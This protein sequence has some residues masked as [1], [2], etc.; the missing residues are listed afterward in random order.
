MSDCDESHGEEQEKKSEHRSGKYN[1]NWV[2]RKDVLV[3]MGNTHV[4]ICE[5][6]GQGQ[7]C[8]GPKVQVSL[9]RL[10]D[11]KEAAAGEQL[12]RKSESNRMKP[13]TQRSQLTEGLECQGKDFVFYVES[14]GK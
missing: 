12:G 14:R 10:D 8:K 11:R 2:I 13:E 9:A 4:G 5:R 7:R 6:H 1:L 3:K